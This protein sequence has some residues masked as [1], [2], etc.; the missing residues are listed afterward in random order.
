M[1]KRKRTRV[2]ARK[3]TTLSWPK[4]ECSGEVVNLSLKGCLMAPEGKALPAVGQAVEVR[5]HLEAG[6]PELDVKAHA[7][8]V[9]RDDE[10]VAVDFTNIE[11]DSFRHLY[12]LVQYNAP[13]ADVIEEELVTAAFQASGE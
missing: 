6:E 8:V 1:D 11:L 5:L 3:R 4:G 12:L 9:R 13:D 2:T 10:G 7:V